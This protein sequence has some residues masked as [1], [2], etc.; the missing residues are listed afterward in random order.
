M[1]TASK[2]ARRHRRL[3][4]VPQQMVFCQVMSSIPTHQEH[5]HKSLITSDTLSTQEK[6]DE[7]MLDNS[8]EEYW[9]EIQMA[10]YLA[11]EIYLH[12][13]QGFLH[14]FVPRNY[15]YPL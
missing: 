1:Q 5:K 8:P 2:G 4:G 10:Q 3:Q 14:F 15:Q 9:L 13:L 12:I 11:H 7:L 6:E